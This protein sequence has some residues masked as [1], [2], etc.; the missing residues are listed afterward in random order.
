MFKFGD[1]TKDKLKH[2]YRTNLN[3]QKELAIQIGVLIKENRK[4]E[5]LI[6]KQDIQGLKQ[7]CRI[8]EEKLK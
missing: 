2:E 4:E 7:R 1:M 3:K 5:A 8:I 6:L